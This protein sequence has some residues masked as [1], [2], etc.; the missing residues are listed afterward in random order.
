MQEREDFD[1]A[2][3]DVVNLDKPFVDKD[4]LQDDED[5]QAQEPGSGPDGGRTDY[6]DGE[7]DGSATTP[8]IVLPT[9]PGG[10][11]TDFP[12]KNL[13]ITYHFNPFVADG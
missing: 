11:G 10:P 3:S 1:F 6:E 4:T 2:D 9:G 12:G 8:P 7:E 5:F 13:F